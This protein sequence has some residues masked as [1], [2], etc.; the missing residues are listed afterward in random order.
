M[1][2]KVAGTWRRDLPLLRHQRQCY[3]GWLR[4]YEADGLDGLKDR[5]SRPHHSPRVTQAD[6]PHSPCSTMQT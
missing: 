6:L 5:S 4:R 3:Y 2:R 1:W